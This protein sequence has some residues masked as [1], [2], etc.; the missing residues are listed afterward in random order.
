[1]AASRGFSVEKKE[2]IEEYKFDS[3]LEY[4]YVES[5]DDF[6]KDKQPNA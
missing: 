1:M 2:E 5:Y 6:M 4:E 3:K